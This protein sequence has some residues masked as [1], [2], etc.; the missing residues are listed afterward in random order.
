V[1][2]FVV[3]V[4]VEVPDPVTEVGLNDPL[5]R[6]GSPPTLKVTVPANGPTGAIVTVY[7]VFDPRR[8]V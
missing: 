1:F 5:E 4:N 8:T 2:L 3:T 7:E 6:F